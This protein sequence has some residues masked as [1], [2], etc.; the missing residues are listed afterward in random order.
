MRNEVADQDFVWIVCR[1]A[2]EITYCAFYITIV[3]GL[4]DV[5]YL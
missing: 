4:S 5:L 2:T 3:A 1:K